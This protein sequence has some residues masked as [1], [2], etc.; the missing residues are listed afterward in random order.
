[1]TTRVYETCVCGLRQLNAA[2]IRSC[3]LI[4]RHFDCCACDEE[5]QSPSGGTVQRSA[6]TESNRI[7][8]IAWTRSSAALA[9][10][11]S[12]RTRH[13]ASRAKLIS[14]WYTSHRIPVR[15]DELMRYLVNI[16]SAPPERRVIYSKSVWQFAYFCRVMLS[17]DK[18]T[19][20]TTSYVMHINFISTPA[21]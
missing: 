5:T 12:T 1:M 13:S 17:K 8:D 2:E 7:S 21:C 3:R 16:C 20:V 11:C 4:C 14:S 9:D 18:T 19:L 10:I 6:E 15:A